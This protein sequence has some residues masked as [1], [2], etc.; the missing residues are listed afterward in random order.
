[1][2]DRIERKR[3]TILKLLSDG[4][5]VLGSAEITRRLE[6]QGHDISERTVRFHLL[7]LDND[8]FT[9]Y[10]GKKG[11][12]LTE[13]GRLELSKA[14]VFEKVGFL[15]SKIDQLTYLMRFDRHTRQG[16]VVVNVSMLER[17][18]LARACPLMA[19]VFEAGYAMGELVTLY[20]PGE[21]AGDLV[22][23]ED[24]VGIGTVCSIT[25]NGILLAE[26]IP[27]TSR[28]GG[29]LELEGGEP[30]RFVAIINYDGT[31]LDPLE[32]FIKSGMTD[33]TGA[34]E[35]GDGLIGASFREVPAASRDRV[36]ALAEELKEIGLNA[37]MSVGWPGQPLLGIPVDEGVAGALV[38]GG[39]NPVAIL[40]ESGIKVF[41][42]ALS[43][44]VDYGR[45]FPYT[46]LEARAASLCR[47]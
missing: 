29:L 19:R 16:S 22:V 41:S 25:L 34:T 12:R 40:E 43:G 42:R 46:E 1:M 14:R 32:I 21:K 20:G 23:P 35:S 37:V 9:E 47:E 27:T 28:F 44:L 11:R 6:S 10:V 8:G 17:R 30:T 18:H 2:Q 3:L 26:G 39:L 45:L 15:T 5:A 36:L 13:K 4:D 31:S 7:A 38:I 24:C 33:Y